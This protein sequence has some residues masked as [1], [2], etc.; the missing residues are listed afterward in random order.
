MCFT[1]KVLYLLQKPHKFVLF[2]THV[3]RCARN[4][5]YIIPATVAV[6]SKLTILATLQGM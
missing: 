1:G 4:L 3:P 2:I 5:E 6:G